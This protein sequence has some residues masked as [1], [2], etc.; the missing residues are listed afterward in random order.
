MHIYAC[1]YLSILA[2]VS[3]FDDSTS[4]SWESVDNVDGVSFVDLKTA[5]VVSANQKLF[6]SPVQD[7]SFDLVKIS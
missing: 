7:M 4:F 2:F 3:S 6:L 5:G 1:M